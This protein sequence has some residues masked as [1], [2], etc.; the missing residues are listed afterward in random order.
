MFTP[1]SN[2]LLPKAYWD[3]AGRFPIDNRYSPESIL[4]LKEN[5]VFVFGANAS[6]F[7]G[8][9]SA[10]WAYTG[11][12]GNQYRLGNPLLKKPK[13]TKGFWATLGVS[14]GPQVGEKGK[15]YAICTIVKPGL[16]RSISLE[17]IKKQVIELYLFAEKRS[18]LIFYVTKSGEINKPS[19]SGYNLQENALC[20]LDKV[21]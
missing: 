14:R 3:F 1:P 19:L 4:E 15:S 21:P 9:G 6:G 7:H 16:K 2:I 8:S 10:G 18:N 13:G 11:K 17:E 5:E 20:Y 12:P